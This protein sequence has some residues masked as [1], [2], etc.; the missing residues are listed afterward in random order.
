LKLIKNL[1]VIVLIGLFMIWSIISGIERLAWY[2]SS[3]YP[4][5]MINKKVNLESK[6]QVY[7]LIKSTCINGESDII[8]RNGALYVRCGSFWPKIRLMKIYIVNKSS[9]TSSSLKK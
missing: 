6:Q 5:F 3:L 1:F 9:S 2:N 4:E 7:D 8:E